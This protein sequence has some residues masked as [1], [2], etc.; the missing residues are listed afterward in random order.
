[1]GKRC[2]NSA[3]E[4]GGLGGGVWGMVMSIGW[5][6]F[7]KNTVRSVVCPLSQAHPDF[8]WKVDTEFL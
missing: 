8:F 3:G 1:M 7:Y 6:P 4:N 5:N 2:E